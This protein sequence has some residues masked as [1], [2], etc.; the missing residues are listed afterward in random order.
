MKFLSN[1]KHP[2]ESIALDSGLCS[3]IAMMVKASSDEYPDAKSFI[4][5]A[6]RY[7]INR[8]KFNIENYDAVVT[9]DGKLIGKSDMAFTRCLMCNRFFLNKKERIKQ[10]RRICPR[11][12]DIVKHLAE[13]L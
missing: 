10:G 8:I 9:K 1:K 11:C 13:K 4:E 12:S 6:A 5:N 7:K 3:E 2:S